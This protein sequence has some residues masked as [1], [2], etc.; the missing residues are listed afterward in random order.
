MQA[1]QPSSV[2]RNVFFN[3]DNSLLKTI[4]TVISGALLLAIAAQISIPLVPV[5]LT[6]QSATVVLIGMAMGPRLGSYV[7]ASYLIAGA[8]GIPV[9]ADFSAGPHVFFG[10]TAGYLMGF[11]PAAFVSGYLAQHGFAK[12]IIGSFVAALIGVSI[13]F[14]CGVAWLSQFVGFAQAVSVG[15]MPFVVSESVKLF[16]AAIVIPKLWKQSRA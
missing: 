6:F 8:S 1:T 9:F 3:T 14:T 7:I 13:I 10:A 5:P 16:A 15:F 2:L 4:L 11:L 12:S